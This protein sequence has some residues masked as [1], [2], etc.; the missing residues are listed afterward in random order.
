MWVLGL[1]VLSALPCIIVPAERVS[2]VCTLL[3]SA[4]WALDS[5]LSQVVHTGYPELTFQDPGI[6][7]SVPAELRSSQ[8]TGAAENESQADIARWIPKGPALR[9]ETPRGSKA[10]NEASW[11]KAHFMSG[12]RAYHI[13]TAQW[14][15]AVPNRHLVA[16]NSPY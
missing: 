12:L 7:P 11:P 14:A 2:Y 3:Y 6:S 9:A 15:P 4:C 13:Q 16:P 5:L 10:S 8:K 1:Q